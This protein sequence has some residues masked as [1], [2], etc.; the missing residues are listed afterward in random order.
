MHEFAFSCSPEY[1]NREFFRR[2]EG[3]MAVDL[4]G[5]RKL[6]RTGALK[7]AF[8]AP[9]PM[10]PG[11]WILLVDRDDGSQEYMAVARTDRYKIYKS[12]E[13]VVADVERVGFNEAKLKVA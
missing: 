10:E 9:A 8:I 3:V 6:Y 12:L 5:M 1:R 11:G 4:S 7:N 13:A 2:F